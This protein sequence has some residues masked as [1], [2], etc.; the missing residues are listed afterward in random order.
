MPS[1]IDFRSSRSTSST[2]ER[3]NLGAATGGWLLTRLDTKTQRGVERVCAVP[4]F[5]RIG[6][7]CS[8]TEHRARKRGIDDRN[9]GREGNRAAGPRATAARSPRARG[10]QG[11]P[12]C[13][14]ALAR[15]WASWDHRFIAGRPVKPRD[16]LC[17]KERGAILAPSP[18]SDPR[19]GASAQLRPAR[20]QNSS[21]EN[22]FRFGGGPS[23]RVS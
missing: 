23:A 18:C 3:R 4:G 16:N 5:P 10:V 21:T 14:P 9:L 13:H 22:Q 19:E 1:G 12:L 15:A 7:P 20:A 8:K 2:S 17:P 11:R 6:E